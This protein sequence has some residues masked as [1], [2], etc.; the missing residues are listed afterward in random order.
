MFQHRLQRLPGED[1][2]TTVTRDAWGIPFLGLLGYE[3][4]YN[5]RALE[6]DGLTF[7]LSHRA[8]DPDDTPPLHVVGARQELGRVAASGRPRLAPHSLVQEYLNR[9]EHLWGIVTNGLTLRLLRDSTFVRR[10][11]YVEFDLTAILE[12]SRF[13][14]FAALYRLLHRT[15][16]P[17]GMADLRAQARG[18][19]LAAAK[20]SLRPL[21]RRVFPATQA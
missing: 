13:Q 20:G 10:Q 4:R 5:P 14:D 8:G 1:L 16:L 3:P 9:T 6:V 7:A 2:A 15:R 12:E 11:A 18:P 17:R 21:E 19:G